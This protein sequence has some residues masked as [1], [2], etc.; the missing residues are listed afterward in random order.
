MCP[1]IDPEDLTL[2]KIH[3]YI[4]SSQA[5]N[6]SLDTNIQ[7]EIDNID[8][9][10]Q[11]L[12]I[13]IPMAGAG[14]RFSKVGYQLPK[15]LILVK[16]KPMIKV[17]VDN[18][19]LNAHYIF[20]VQRSHYEKYNLECVLNLVAP[21]CDIVKVD[22]LTEGAV[23]TVL[24]ARNLIN[25]SIPLLLANSD[26]FVEWS[27]LRFMYQSMSSNL[28]GS[29][30]TFQAN[31]PKWSFARLDEDGFVA[32][33]AEKK[34]ISNIATAGIYFWKRGS[35]FCYYADK[36]IEKNI[37]VNGEFYLA[38]VYNEAIIDKKKF[39]VIPCEKMWGY[40]LCASI[41][42]ILNVCMSVLCEVMYV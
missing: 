26:Q 12:N 28:D 35:D 38:P 7:N 15:P 42:L 23:C 41:L 14:S 34:P 3:H 22:G 40:V 13:V 29:L 16:G 21:G 1:I 9:T 6:N 5:H 8:T 37:R 39:R 19:A 32:E 31:D 4:S 11:R 30:L 24:S 27:S 25:S 20:I 33:V 36:M 17:V 10:T 2:E 18:L